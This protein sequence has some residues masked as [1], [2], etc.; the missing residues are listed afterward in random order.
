MAALLDY[1]RLYH[2]R[3]VLPS[4]WPVGTHLYDWSS[5]DEHL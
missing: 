2:P 1:H 5:G 3:L 4:D